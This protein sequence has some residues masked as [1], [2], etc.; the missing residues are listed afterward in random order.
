MAVVAQ[1]EKA[2]QLLLEADADLNDQIEGWGSV[3]QLAIFQGNE[4]IAKYLLEANAD[5]N[6]HCEGDFGGVRHP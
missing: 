4:L 5:P 1:N 6:L 3:L 2:V